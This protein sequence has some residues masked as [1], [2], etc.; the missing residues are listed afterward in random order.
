MING[1]HKERLSSALEN[2]CVSDGDRP[3]SPR[4]SPSWT[5]PPS[6][7]LPILTCYLRSYQI[8]CTSIEGLQLSR[9]SYKNTSSQ[10][11]DELLRKHALS[12][13]IQCS[14]DMLQTRTNHLR[15]RHAL[16]VTICK[17]GREPM[18]PDGGTDFVVLKAVSLA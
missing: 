5:L 15:L 16:H 14:L 1:C 17:R 9:S 13:T 18:V 4:S 8:I 2:P 11:N 7:T 12:L 10:L 3:A 6:T